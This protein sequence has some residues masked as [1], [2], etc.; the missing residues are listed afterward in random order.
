MVNLS[1]I[2]VDHF[3]VFY[4][5]PNTLYLIPGA[6]SSPR[7]A[8]CMMD[9]VNG[10]TIRF[11]P[12]MH[13]YHIR[14]VDDWLMRSLTCPTCMQR[15]DLTLTAN[16]NLWSQSSAHQRQSS[17]SSMSSESSQSSSGS[18]VRLRSSRSVVPPPPPLQ[19]LAS[20]SSV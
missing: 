5:I 15:V 12:C 17:T 16:Q 7:C 11:L 3:C 1:S 4:Q 6:S 18:A 8:I 20:V 19:R 9:F 10:D 14:C 13:Y 2:H